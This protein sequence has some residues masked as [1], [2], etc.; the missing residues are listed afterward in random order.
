LV[1]SVDA[2]PATR[3]RTGLTG[4]YSARATG[5]R[6]MQR[7]QLFTLT[8]SPRSPPTDEAERSRAPKAID[9]AGTFFGRW[10]A[11]IL[12]RLLLQS[13]TAHGPAKDHVCRAGAVL[14]TNQAAPSLFWI[15]S[16]NKKV[17][18]SN[19]TGRFSHYDIHRSINCSQGRGVTRCHA[20]D[21]RS[22]RFPRAETSARRADV[23]FPAPIRGWI[24][25]RREASTRS[26]R[27][28]LSESS[29]GPSAASTSACPSPRCR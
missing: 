6:L 20:F 4:L 14:A 17:K 24:A 18:K 22:T 12:A 21:A 7:H 27:W 28:A 15:R 29:R 10:V 2:H 9:L 11:R 16:P 3:S 23:T 19:K 13:L 1:A 5:Q 8:P 26:R 25:S